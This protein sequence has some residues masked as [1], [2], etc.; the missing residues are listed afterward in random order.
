MSVAQV[1]WNI[2][3]LDGMFWQVNL[4]LAR[5]VQKVTDYLLHKVEPHAHKKTWLPMHRSVE[6]AQQ[7]SENAPGMFATAC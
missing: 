2:T 7:Q 4:T 1:N 6:K 5:S 3:A